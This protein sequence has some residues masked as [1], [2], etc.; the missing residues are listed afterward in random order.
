MQIVIVRA[1]QDPSF[2]IAWMTEQRLRFVEVTWQRLGSGEGGS[3]RIRFRVDSMSGV[4]SSFKAR[5][6]SLNPHACLEQA[7]DG[8]G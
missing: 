8:G 1:G 6:Q 7:G 3:A 5:K 2:F 4:Y